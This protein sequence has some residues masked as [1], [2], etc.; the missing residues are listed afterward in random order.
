[1]TWRK[2]EI[3]YLQTTCCYQAAALKHL[4]FPFLFW[5]QVSDGLQAQSTF[6]VSLFNISIFFWSQFFFWKNNFLRPPSIKDSVDL[7]FMGNTYGNGFSSQSR[8]H[9]I[10]ASGD[11]AVGIKSWW[12]ARKG[13]ICLPPPRCRASLIKKQCKSQ[14]SAWR[15]KYFL[16]IQGDT[17]THFTK[18]WI[19]L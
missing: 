9:G 3:I 19:R 1:M 17:E 2:Q 11:W 6:E 14:R 13:G 7:S 5:L 12:K 8:Q 4:T 10:E 15:W 18:H 16:E